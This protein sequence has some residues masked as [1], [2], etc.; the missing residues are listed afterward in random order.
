[1]EADLEMVGRHVAQGDRHI[2][3]QIEIVK[4]LSEDGHDTVQ[5]EWLL[6]NFLESQKLHLAHY[7]RLLKLLDGAG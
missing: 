2:Q 4:E 6:A 3:R 5:A 7:E 1:V